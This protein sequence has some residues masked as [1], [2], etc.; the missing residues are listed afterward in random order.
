MLRSERHLLNV[1]CLMLLPHRKKQEP[2]L[3][4]LGRAGHSG[5]MAGTNRNPRYDRL[6][7]LPP[8]T[9]YVEHGKAGR[10][11]LYPSLDYRAKSN[12][13]FLDDNDHYDYR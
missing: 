8:V 11:T 9:P 6:P 10:D 5:P 12:S 1:R 4:D 7:P 3:T 2:V 13:G